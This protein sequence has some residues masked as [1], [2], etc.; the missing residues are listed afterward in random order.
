MKSGQPKLSVRPPGAKPPVTALTVEESLR[1]LEAAGE[2]SEEPAR[3]VAESI[4]QGRAVEPITRTDASIPKQNDAPVRAKMPW[5]EEGVESVISFNFK[6]PGKLGAKLKYLGGTTYGQSMTSIVVE[7]LEV[8][9]AAMM[10][11]RGL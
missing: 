5:E 10:K 7:A 3:Q 4:G 11:E 9:I 6:I 1:R 8:K 2:W